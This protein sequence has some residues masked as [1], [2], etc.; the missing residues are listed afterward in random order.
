MS[1]SRTISKI[2]NSFPNLELPVH[3][4]CERDGFKITEIIK[5]NNNK[6]NKCIYCEA[7]YSWE[8]T[9]RRQFSSQDWKISK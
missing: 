9:V 2:L 6:T 4:I 3:I 5:S 1:D 8:K 7:N